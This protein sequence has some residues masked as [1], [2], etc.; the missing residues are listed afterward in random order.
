MAAIFISGAKLANTGCD[1]GH[2]LHVPSRLNVTGPTAKRYRP[3]RSS[4]ERR[5]PGSC[6]VKSDNKKT[7]RRVGARLRVARRT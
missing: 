2:A 1:E 5:L 6:N 7:S 3:L 4:R